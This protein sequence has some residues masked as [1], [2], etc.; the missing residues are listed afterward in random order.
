MKIGQSALC[1]IRAGRS[2]RE[3][4]AVPREI[5]SFSDIVKSSACAGLPENAGCMRA[6]F[7]PTI[8]TECAGQGTEKGRRAPS[9]ERAR[10]I[11]V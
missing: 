9:C 6:C 1:R 10:M 2:C 8:R 7:P 3:A 11:R 5:A 4:R